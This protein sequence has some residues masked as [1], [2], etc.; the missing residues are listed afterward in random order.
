MKFADDKMLVGGGVAWLVGSERGCQLHGTPWPELSS[1]SPLYV[2]VLLTNF[3][4]N[5]ATAG[6]PHTR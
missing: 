1:A 2:N 4:Q 3:E 5:K 6:L